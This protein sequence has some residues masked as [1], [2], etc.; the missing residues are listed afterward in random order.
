MSWSITLGRIFGIDIKM[1]LTF[2]LILFWGA[3]FYGGEAGPFYGVFLTLSLFTIV[4]LHE[5]GHSVAA[6]VFGVKVKDIILLP[7]GG[8]ARLEKM[9]DKPWQELIVALAGPLVNVGL[10]FLILPMV[11]FL[12]LQNQAMTVEGML[13][14]S[15]FG[16]LM[17]LLVT[18]LSLVLFN[19]LPAFPLD[20]GRVFRAGLAIFMDYQRATNIAVIIGRM[21]AIGL[22]L[23]GLVTFEFILMLIALFI[24]VAAGQENRAVAVRDILRGVP[25]GR[26]LS[27]D[28]IAFTPTAT[29]QQVASKV[30][31][32]PQPNF[33][34]LDP[35][36]HQFLGMT[37]SKEVA[38]AM[39]RG[40]WYKQVADIMHHARHIP[41]VALHAS[42]DEV[43][44]KLSHT[45][46]RVVAVYDGLHFRGLIDL[47]DIYR[48][49]QLFSQVSRR[50]L[51]S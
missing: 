5:L 27:P 31:H 6:L 50:E 14:P 44:E 1:H 45:S 36:D 28:A 13:Q 29:I 7:I 37:T 8:V 10:F 4:L 20:G 22:G 40:Q 23:L 19:M 30:I 35:T 15:L 51:A 17:F 42:L 32:S 49:F 38:N 46:S 41:K 33:A 2:L 16:F 21:A 43:Q 9:P 12:G 3:I 48:A 25:A 39:A 26:I 18:N 47:D 34:I 11:I 24:Y